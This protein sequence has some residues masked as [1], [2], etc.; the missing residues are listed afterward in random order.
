MSIALQAPQLAHAQFVKAAGGLSP[1]VGEHISFD[2]EGNVIVVGGFQSSSIDFDADNIV[3]GDTHST[4]GNE[5]VFIAKYN[6]SGTLVWVKA[7]GSTDRDEARAVD[8]DS[9]DNIYVS[10]LFRGTVDFDPENDVSG[11]TKTSSNGS[12][13]VAKYNASG[14]LQWV[15]AMASAGIGDDL[16]VSAAGNVYVTGYFQGSNVDFDQENDISGDTKSSNGDFEIFIAKYSASGVLQWVNV[17]GGNSEDASKSVTLDTD[18]NVY[19][20]G[21]F[22]SSSVDFSPDAVVSNDTKSNAGGFDIFLAKYNTSGLLQWVKAIGGTSGEQ[23]RE[24]VSSPNGNIL[25]TGQF[26]SNDVDFDP[27]NIISGDTRSPAGSSDIFIAAYNASGDL[28]MLKTIGGTSGDVGESI[29][30][31][32]SNN[33]YVTGFYQSSLV[34]FDPDHVV[35]GDTRSA[36]LFDAFVTKYNS[37]GALQWIKEIS[38]SGVNRGNSI[39]ASASGEVLV[40]GFFSSTVDFDPDRVL[41]NDTKSSLGSQPALFVARYSS[42]GAL[43]VELTSFSA[44]IAPERS[45]VWLLWQTASET[46]NAGFEIQRQQ[47]SGWAD[48]AF[49]AGH[50]TTVET[51]EY[52]YAVSGLEPGRH[53]FRLKQIDYDGAFTYSETISL[54]VPS[55]QNT[56]TSSLFP[57]PVVGI[58]QLHVTVGRSQAVRVSIYDLLGRERQLLYS[59]PL[60]ANVPQTFAVDRNGLPNGLYIIRLMGDLDSYSKEFTVLR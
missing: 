22:Q 54:D 36:N 48:L 29:S 32:G 18:G 21:Y 30:V 16:V 31:D 5:D 42:S 47:D 9:D 26:A 19:I 8:L 25:V 44:R 45:T 12:G 58:S 50:G 40:T 53:T 1:D 14:T 7:V 27:S 52:S 24:V 35:S 60:E 37:A 43:P 39:H 56:L 20:T 10:G 34:D 2:S 46:N 28:Q 51:S 49:I 4:N 59:G 33:F 55:S 13:F 3:S 6:P 15:K 57:N 38:S 17:A 41:S 23:G 11:D